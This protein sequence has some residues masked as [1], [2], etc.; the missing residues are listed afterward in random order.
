MKHVQP[1]ELM[2]PKQEVNALLVYPTFPPHTYWSF[3]NVLGFAGRKSA[4]PPLGLLTIASMLPSHWKP[5]LVDMNVRPLR[6]RDIEQA[7]IVLVSAMSVQR[8]SLEEV[9]NRV[10]AQGKRV[11][12]GGTHI[13]TAVHRPPQHEGDTFILGEAE[14]AFPRYLADLASGNPLPIYD[15]QE[16]KP[17]LTETP[18][19][20]WDLIRTSH[21]GSM[22]LQYSRGCPFDCEFCDIIEI[23]GRRPRVKDDDQFLVEMDTLYATRYRGPL[24]V[25]DDNLIGNLPRVKKLVPK[26]RRWME[27]KRFPFSLYTEASVNLAQQPKLLEEMVAA[28]FRRVFFGIETP[29]PKSLREAQKGQNLRGNLLDAVHKVQRAGMQV[30][31]GFIVGFDSDPPDID[32]RQ[33]DFI[34]DSAIPL[35]MVGVLSALPGTQLYRRLEQ[36]GRLLETASGNNTEGQINFTTKMDPRALREG[37]HRITTTIY[38]ARTYYE[39]V[40]NF[41]ARYNPRRPEPFHLQDLLPSI[42]AVASS[43]V[44]QGVLDRD[45]WEYWKFMG[46]VLTKYR[47][48]A[49]EAITLA[50]M[51]H[52]L[53]KVAYT[54]ASAYRA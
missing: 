21:Y 49:K 13:T 29:E 25:V 45:R 43:M 23:Y 54:N 4:F 30:M 14:Q 9:V 44:H 34:E 35:A 5:R 12:I 18:L 52:H 28:G 27:E 10:H 17:A 39:R 2:D 46:N 33:I 20:R 31:G 51:G 53:R 1:T 8:P 50:I 38:G 42:R 16:D 41:L 36:E 26:I 19:A 32:K 47:K 48:K 3:S 7:D 24:F 11:V 40:S 15:G 37:F 22:N 6:D